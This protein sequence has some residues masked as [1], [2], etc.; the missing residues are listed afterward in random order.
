MKSIDAIHLIKKR[1]EE[2]HVENLH[3]AYELFELGTGV[4][5]YNLEEITQAQFQAIDSYVSRRIQGEPLQYLFG[6]WPFLD[7][8]VLVDRRAFIPRPETELLA[9]AAISRSGSGPILDL[10]SG[11]GVLALALKRAHP[12]WD[13][14]AVE[15]SSESCSLIKEN[16]SLLSL[17]LNVVNE[18]VFT[19]LPTLH[20]PTFQTIVCNPPY[21]SEKDYLA[22]YDELKYEPKGAFVASNGGLDF[23]ERLI[24]LCKTALY[25]D[26]WL[27]FEIGNEQGASVSSLMESNGFKGVQVL[28]DYQHLDR[29]VLGQAP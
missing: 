18:D 27:L 26:G 2:H 12:Q 23:Y 13:V 29:I 20:A 25:S 9:E 22:N 28:Q 5:Y 15:I 17:E 14:T 11:S 6:K 10:C 4:S 8:E 16:C 3:E 19:Y 21:V 1:L 7:F 24:P